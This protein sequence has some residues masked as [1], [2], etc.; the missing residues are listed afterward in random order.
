MNLFAFKNKILILM[1]TTIVATIAVSFISVKSVINDYIY[2]SSMQDIAKD[3]SLIE[4]NIN[5]YLQGKLNLVDSIEFGIM[6]IKS[7]KDKLDFARV[8][9]VMNRM[10]LSDEGSM[11]DEQA[12]QYIQFAHAHPEGLQVGEVVQQAEQLSLTLSRKKKNI[13]D[14]FVLDLHALGSLIEKFSREGTYFELIAENGVMI[15]SNKPAVANLQQSHRNLSIGNRGWQLISYIDQQFIAEQTTRINTK[16]NI[17]LMSCAL[18]MLL[19]SSLV[20][21]LLLRP[22]ERLRNL[23]QGL[24]AGEADLTQRLTVHS[25][26]E[27]GQIS[28]AIN[29]FMGQIQEIF[30]QIKRTNLQIAPFI[31]QLN[32]QAKNNMLSAEQHSDQ[33]Q[34]I[35][36]AMHSVTLLSN[37]AQHSSVQAAEFVQSVKQQMNQSAQAGRTA[38]GSM[39][40]LVQDVQA[41][42]DQVQQITRDSQAISDILHTIKQ[43]ADQ[44][45]LLAL[46]AAIEAARAG[47]SGRG[48]AVVAEEVRTLAARTGSCTTQI[49]DLLTQFTQTTRTIHQKMA[50]T[51]HNCHSSEAS[52][53]TVVALLDEMT[54]AIDHILNHNLSVSDLVTQQTQVISSVNDTMTELNQIVANMSQNEKMA[55]Q[56]CGQLTDMSAELSQYL[57]CFRT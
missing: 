4:D 22:V 28:Q 8:V 10:A 53:A 13:V 29:H 20:L 6:H 50:S 45:N 19:L 3:V 46:N 37:Q 9:K 54:L 51:Q 57:Q 27:L 11:A 49:D 16:I 7:T 34:D 15:Y 35:V 12:Q 52:S 31:V 48:F 38:S 40:T 56:A 26:D 21:Q 23:V 30:V 32:D 1:M 55:Y 36:K 18:V 43:I 24:T 14:F 25:R 17:Y 41:M 47:E 44:T 33:T 39:D 2:Q 5:E 42:A